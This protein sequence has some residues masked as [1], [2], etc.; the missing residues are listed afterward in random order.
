VVATH[1]KADV[2]KTT[3]KVLRFHESQKLTDA[4][5]L[6]A[7]KDSFSELSNLNS[8]IEDFRW[9]AKLQVDGMRESVQNYIN[10]TIKYLHLAQ[11]YSSLS[12]EAQSSLEEIALTT[13]AETVTFAQKSSQISLNQVQKM[14]ESLKSAHQKPKQLEQTLKIAFNKTKLEHSKTIEAWT[15]TSNGN[16]ENHSKVSRNTI[17]P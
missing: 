12:P 9:K 11:R 4:V 8:E 10:Q 16:L 5:L 15:Q 7:K 17:Y 2:G 13:K 3:K 1:I 6:Q 14:F